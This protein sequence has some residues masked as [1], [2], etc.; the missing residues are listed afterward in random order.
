LPREES[1]LPDAPISCKGCGEAL[2]IRQVYKALGSAVIRKGT[3]KI[4]FK[5]PLPELKGPEKAAAAM[6]SL[7][8]LP[9]E[10]KQVLSICFDNEA[11]TGKDISANFWRKRMPALAVADGVSYVATA[12]PGYPFDLITKVKKACSAPGDAYIHILCPCPVGWAYDASLSVKVGKLAVDTNLF[13]LYE[14]VQGTYFMT[15][16]V[17]QPRP[18]KEYLRLQERFQQFSDADI[19]EIQKL[20]TLEYSRLS[21]SSQRGEGEHERHGN[22]SH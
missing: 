17:P 21:A 9:K 14:A 7:L 12:S 1:F 8:R 6:P 15:V 19:E 16:A 20:V 22:K 5:Q 18:V 4:P 2:A 11:R 10:D 3:W 13:P